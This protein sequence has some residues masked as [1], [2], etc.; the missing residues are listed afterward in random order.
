MWSLCR[1]ITRQRMQPLSHS[2]ALQIRTRAKPRAPDL[3]IM[4]AL[5][6]EQIQGIQR[7]VGQFSQQM[8]G[9]I[10]AQLSQAEPPGKQIGEA[11]AERRQRRFVVALE[12]AKAMR[13]RGDFA[14]SS[15]PDDDEEGAKISSKLMATAVMDAE[16][17]LAEIERSEAADQIKFNEQMQKATR[18]ANEEKAAP[19]LPRVVPAPANTKLPPPPNANRQ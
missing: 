14:A 3:K 19:G 16:N 2:R 11:F 1:R 8:A 6:N 13:A 15:I 18:E 5:T 10:I 17:L 12:M 7:Y 9:G 4:S